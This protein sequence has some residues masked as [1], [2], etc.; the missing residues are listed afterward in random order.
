VTIWVILAGLPGTGKSTLARALAQRIGG[1]VLDKDRIRAAL[2]PGDLTDYSA[3]QDDV[4][5]RAVYQAAAYLTSHNRSEFVFLDGRTF[6]HSEQIAV[7]VAAAEQ[8]GAAWRILHVV[9]ADEIAEARLKAPDAS[10]P[11][12]NRDVGL[13]RAIKAR[14]EAI[15]LPHLLVDTSDGVEPVIERVAA[16]LFHPANRER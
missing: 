3:E 7:A 12:R 10:N 5:M 16:S 8:A 14:F 2:F 11:A 9:C 13:Y 6:S 1:V 15:A 4:C